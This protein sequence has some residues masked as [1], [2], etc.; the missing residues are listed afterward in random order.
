MLIAEEIKANMG[1][2]RPPSP[3]PGGSG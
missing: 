2:D 3:G 1:I